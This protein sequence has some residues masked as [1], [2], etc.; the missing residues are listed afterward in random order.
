M[1]RRKA[2]RQTVF[3]WHRR[4]GLVALVLVIIIAVTGIM[5]NHTER[6]E[7]DKTYVGSALILNWYGL[8]PK[9][10]P[11]S[12]AANGHTISQW[13]Q[14]IFFD[15]KVT[16]SSEQSLHGVIGS[17]RFIALAFDNELLL[18][19]DQGEVIE[20]I[21][22]SF[23][24]IQRLGNKDN[25][26]VIETINRHYYQADANIIDWRTIKKEGIVWSEPAEI[27]NALRKAL[28]QGY[29]GKGLSLERV[30]LDMHSGRIFGRYGVYVMDAAAIALL[31]LSLSGLWVWWR[32][33]QK[34]KSKR[35]YRK[36]HRV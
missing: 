13:Q 17:D 3:L 19:S 34:Q 6:F 15:D 31:W 4:I 32:R 24:K 23:G 33:Q 30:I 8:E 9:G 28:L 7:L 2:K 11:L 35:H 14:Q 18:L 36:H 5:L 1:T 29:R 25:R 12:Y 22:A 27:N 10:E 20:H 26:L 21:P 16:T